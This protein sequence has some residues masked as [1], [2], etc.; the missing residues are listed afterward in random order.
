MIGVVIIPVLNR[1][2]LLDACIESVPDSVREI[3]VIDN[4]DQLDERDDFDKYRWRNRS[5]YVRVLNMPSNLGVAASWNLGIK[6]Y[7]FEAGWLLLN[8]DARFGDGAFAEFSEHVSESN[9]VQAGVPPW[10][11]T[12]VG[13]RVVEEVGLFCEVFYPAYMEDLDY[14]E[15]CRI[16][17][18]PI[19][20]SGAR[21]E[22]DNSSTIRSDRALSELNDFTHRR[23][24]QAYAERWGRVDELG[25]PFD[26]EW[27]LGVRRANAW[28]A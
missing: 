7:P 24:A 2:D 20:M 28:D 9:L 26:A 25:L 10:C 23:N 1:Y 5:T 19:V 8:S 22:H 6:L 14:E 18:V 15:R 3:L 12:W 16:L 17:N 21:V 11:C 13:S 27:R 4:G